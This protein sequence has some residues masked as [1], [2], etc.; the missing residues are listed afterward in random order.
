MFAQDGKI[1][2]LGFDQN[3]EILSLD[4]AKVLI[5]LN[6]RKFETRE[7][8]DEAKVWDGDVPLPGA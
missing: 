1:F 3:G 8:P 2:R 6:D 5:D 7:S 4:K